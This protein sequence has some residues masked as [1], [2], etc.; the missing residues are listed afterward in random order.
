MEFNIGDVVVLKSG[1]PEM[2]IK[3]FAWNPTTN[4]YSLNRVTCQ[5]FDK[6]MYYKNFFYNRVINKNLE[7][8]RKD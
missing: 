7:V 2:T 3:E 8:I 4:S 6:K 5:W 1:G